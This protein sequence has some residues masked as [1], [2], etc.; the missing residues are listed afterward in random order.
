MR[1][2]LIGPWNECDGCGAGDLGDS[3]AAVDVGDTLLSEYCHT[4]KGSQRYCATR[5]EPKRRIVQS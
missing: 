4:W 1:P 2:S 5:K 3:D